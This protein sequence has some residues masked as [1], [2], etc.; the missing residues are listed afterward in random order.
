MF[1]TFPHTLSSGTLFQSVYIYHMHTTSVY[2]IL[3]LIWIF[4]YLFDFNLHFN[5]PTEN[6]KHTEKNVGIKCKTDKYEKFE[7]LY[8]LLK[9]KLMKKSKM[10]N[11]KKKQPSDVNILTHSNLLNLLYPPYCSVPPLH[12]TAKQ[13]SKLNSIQNLN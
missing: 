7:H 12:P 4:I 5:S 11:M 9:H 10:R 2:L 13:L 1:P 3:F 6:T 8:K